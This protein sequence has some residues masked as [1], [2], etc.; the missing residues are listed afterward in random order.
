MGHD[1]LI[2][3]LLDA[4]RGRHAMSEA[5][6]FEDASARIEDELVIQRWRE[7]IDAVARCQFDAIFTF[8]L[9]GKVGVDDGTD[10]EGQFFL[11]NRMGFFGSLW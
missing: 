6:R 8:Q 10:T 2:S 5:A 3:N 9:L 7:G 11:E 4:W 1:D